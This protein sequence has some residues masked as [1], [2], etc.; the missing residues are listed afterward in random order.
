MAG[1][2]MMEVSCDLFDNGDGTISGLSTGLMWIQ[3]S[4]F[5]IQDADAAA[6]SNKDGAKICANTL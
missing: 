3:D 5:R 4:G 2:S 6:P 1:L